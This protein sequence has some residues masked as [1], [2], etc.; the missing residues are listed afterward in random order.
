MYE[1]PQHNLINPSVN[2][3]IEP[4]TFGPE[5][6]KKKRHWFRRIA[7]V[8]IVIGIVLFATSIF[9]IGRFVSGVSKAEDAFNSAQSAAVELDF[10]SANLSLVDA[11]D[12]LVKARSGLTFLKWTVVV[13]WVGDQVQA[14]IAVVDAG[15][16]S[17]RALE[18]AVQIA[19][20][21]LDVVSGIEEILASLE[22]DGGAT[23][24][25]L[26]SETKAELLRALSNA[27]PNL[28][29]AQVSL[30]LAG[31]DLDRLSELNV[32][33][34]L[35]AAVQPFQE[36]LPSLIA[37]VDVL[38]PFA[39]TVDEIAGV[40]EDR[41][42]LVLFLNNTEMRPGGGFMG[43]Y[44]LLQIRDGEIVSLEVDDTYAV[45]V[46]V[47]EL[48]SYQVAPPEPLNKYVGVSKWYFRDANWSPDFPTSSDY[49]VDLLRQELSAAGRPV[50]EIHGVIGFTPDFA[51]SLLDIV[52][53]VTVDGITFNSDNLTSLLEYEVE[54][55]FADKDIPF[56]QRKAIVE[57]LSDTI[58]EELLSLEVSRFGEV[59]QKITESFIEKHLAIYSTDA[60]AQDAFVE[61][62]WAQNLDV[63][64]TDDV[65]MV[66][67]ANMAA[68]KT[69]PVVDREITYSI[70]S[71][72]NDYIATTSIKYT[73]SGKFS[74]LTTRYR[75]YTKIFVPEGSEFISASGTL[76]NDKLS[77][78]SLTEGEVTV[79]DELGM[80]SFGAFTSIEPGDE[81]TLSFTYRLPESVSDAIDRKLYQ[82]TVFKQIG[83]AN[84]SLTLDLNFDKKVKT[85]LPSEQSDEFGDNSYHVDTTLQEDS[86][87]TIEF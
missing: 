49:S 35:L 72:G 62:G 8:L 57:R 22:V 65:L 82:L 51:A 54:F 44:G 7:I 28:Q 42:W 30:R 48:D 70:E 56:E 9:G 17:V 61:A 83:A 67:D 68:L 74:L 4:Q 15:V 10:E 43:V 41:Q 23:F 53:P 1:S 19:G 84:H 75:T 80:T 79:S 12:G 2:P 86:V 24:R 71:D 64:S 58:L 87:F 50:P 52:G 21:V 47:A 6:A 40:D 45:D 36:L 77:N 26:P 73:N 60:G 33:P 59:F 32:H 81:R 69:D 20:E 18:Q 85:A 13:P 76:L 5:S 78:P 39:A 37:G 16:E 25:D 31:D 63:S 34:R 66:V 3:E 46:L 27:L 38:V 11:E 29:E 55:G 14:L